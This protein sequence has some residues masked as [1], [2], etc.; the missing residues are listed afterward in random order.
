MTLS[1][2]PRRA[3]AEGIG[4]FF[5]VLI[6]PGAVVVDA[7]SQGA[8]G[9]TGIALAFAMVVLAMVHALGR[10]SGAHINPAVTIA[11]WSRGRIRREDV[12]PYILAQCAGAV[13]A[14]AVLR[15]LLG[16]TGK[17]GA[18][19]PHIGA[20]GSFV[21]EALMSFVLMLVI[22]AVVTDRNASG[23]AAPAI[24]TTVGFCALLGPLTGSSMNP[25][26]SFGPAIAGGGWEG[27]WI[28]W[29]APIIG[30]LAAAWVYE[31]LLGLHERRETPGVTPD[32]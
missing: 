14:A 26:R 17:V 27:H 10:I 32:S 29:G 12:L 19:V 7:W 23:V 16:T 6:G 20:G 15:F 31:R 9:V 8:L 5:L 4:T 18:T 28:Y 21:I 30:M 25:A 13:A 2:L 1:S 11:L 3:V 24:G 22:M